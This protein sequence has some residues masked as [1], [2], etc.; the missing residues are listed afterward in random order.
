VQN[1]LLGELNNAIRTKLE[2]SDGWQLLA[3][4]NDPNSKTLLFEYPS[5]ISKGGYIHP[6]VKSKSE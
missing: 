6:V 4:L 5:K 1:K 2:T 3:D